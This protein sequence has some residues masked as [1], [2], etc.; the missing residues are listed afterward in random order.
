MGK[1]SLKKLTMS[2]DRKQSLRRRVIQVL[3]A[4]LYNGDVKMFASGG[5]IS[6]SPLKNICVPGLN[7]YSCP[8]AIASCPLGSLQS[9]IGSGRFPLFIIGF[10][11]LMGVLLGRVVC[12]FL[13]PFGLFQELIYKIPSPKLRKTPRS[14]KFTRP[15]SFLKYG[16]LVALCIVIPLLLYFR[17]GIGSPTFCAWVC[18]AG[19]VEA[20]IP[21]VIADPT[22]RE[23][24]GFLFGWKM[25][26]LI[27]FLVSFVFIFR[28]FC[29]FFC[30]LGAIYSFFNRVA[31][32]GIKVDEDKCVHCNACV[33]NCEMDTLVINDRECIRCGKCRKHCKF[34]AI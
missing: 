20:G 5:G 18:P 24:L 27:L 15:L 13:C 16:L 32:F 7:C 25:G 12:G 14:L 11:I 1:F 22:L 23:Q 31:L 33:K 21:L 4:V 30:P 8:G 29:R 9:S 28:F 19:T 10:F 34:G 17:D 26:L 3:A 6:R 2:L